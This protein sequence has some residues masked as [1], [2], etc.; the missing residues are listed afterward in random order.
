V[1]ACIVQISA[2]L[3]AP[4]PDAVSRQYSNPSSAIRRIRVP[5]SCVMLDPFP[6]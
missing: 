1:L 4:A 5:V 6:T 2:A 3:S